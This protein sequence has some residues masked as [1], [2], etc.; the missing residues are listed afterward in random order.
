MLKFTDLNDEALYVNIE[1]D[2]YNA[3]KREYFLGDKNRLEQYLHKK[4]SILGINT[5][6][7]ELLKKVIALGYKATEISTKSTDGDKVDNGDQV[8]E[9]REL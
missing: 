4:M 8:G 2:D 3:M 7:I 1:M 6:D 5:N 9:Q